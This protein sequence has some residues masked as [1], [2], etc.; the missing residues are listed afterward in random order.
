MLAPLFK[1]GFLW[2]SFQKQLPHRTL[3][4]SKLA[5]VIAFASPPS[6]PPCKDF[7]KRITIH[8]WTLRSHWLKFHILLC[9]FVPICSSFWM[10]RNLMDT[11]L[12]AFCTG[13]VTCPT[14]GHQ[15]GQ[16][17]PKFVRKHGDVPSCCPDVS[18]PPCMCN[19]NS[20]GGKFKKQLWKTQRSQRIPFQ[21]CFQLKHPEQIQSEAKLSQETPLYA[22]LLLA[23]IL[24]SSSRTRLVTTISHVGKTSLCFWSNGAMKLSNLLIFAWISKPQPS[25]LPHA[26]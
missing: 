17:V 5:H 15:W 7:K 25:L 10:F 9:R 1:H 13:S 6:S 8:I 18:S 24:G 26:K 11:S 4:L 14:E 21:V 20:L 2:F 12:T 22:M 23:I 3:F 16:T 19:N